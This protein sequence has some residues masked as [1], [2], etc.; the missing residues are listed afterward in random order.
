MTSEAEFNVTLYFK[1]HLA[2][3]KDSLPE[4][5]SRQKFVVYIQNVAC[6]TVK[7]AKGS[8]NSQFGPINVRQV[9]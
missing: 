1:R 8:R 9:K 4:S 2:R 5:V 3:L 7:R 6:P